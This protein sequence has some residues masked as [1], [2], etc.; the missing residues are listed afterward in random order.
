MGQ[1]HGF[2]CTVCFSAVAWGCR[3]LHSCMQKLQKTA[4]TAK[5]RWIASPSRKPIRPDSLRKAFAP[6]IL[7]SLQHASHRKGCLSQDLVSDTQKKLPSFQS[8]AS[9]FGPSVIDEMSNPS[10][11]NQDSQADPLGPATATE[12]SLQRRRWRVQQK[13][14]EALIRHAPSV[15]RL[16]NGQVKLAI[17][18]E[19]ALHKVLG[20]DE[21][22]YTK[23]ARSIIFNLNDIENTDFR[24]LLA[25]GFIRPDEVPHLLPEEMAS[26]ERTVRRARMRK[27]AMEEVQSD[28]ECKHALA[29]VDSVLLCDRCGSTKTTHFELQ[30]RSCDE[31][32]TTYVLELRSEMEV[33]ID[34][35]R[36]R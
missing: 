26:Y 3:F 34:L 2:K 27:A 28:W 10:P 21:K 20:N 23:Q 11:E 29:Q 22:A 4:A 12:E 30:T 31:P 17:E 14:Q 6:G 24:S 25:V 19:H 8:S 16:S 7:G 9:T 33:L 15:K 5:A 36:S 35:E 32:A 18:I 13:I 1:E